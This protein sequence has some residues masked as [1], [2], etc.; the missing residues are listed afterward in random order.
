M[1][2]G[3][4]M[5]EIDLRDSKSIDQALELI[6]RRARELAPDQ[7]LT[8]GRFDKKNWGPWPT[9]AHLDG[10]PGGRPP[11]M[12]SRARH[13]RWL[14]PAPRPAAKDGKGTG[15]PEARAT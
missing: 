1:W 6:G 4:Q 11:G 10:A 3:F 5:A 15:A 9:P 7:W 8:G 14:N 2:W 12:R 13:P